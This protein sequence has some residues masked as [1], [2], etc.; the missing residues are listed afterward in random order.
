ME[1]ANKCHFIIKIININNVEWTES[2]LIVTAMTYISIY[3]E[4]NIFPGK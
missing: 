3:D 2:V 4:Q 1:V